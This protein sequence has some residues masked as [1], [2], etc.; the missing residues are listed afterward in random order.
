M[1]IRY[2]CRVALQHQTNPFQ[3]MYLKTLA[4]VLVT[5]PLATRA[6]G[7][8]IKSGS[9]GFLYTKALRGCSL[10]LK[11][12]YILLAITLDTLIL[13]LLYV[14]LHIVRLMYRY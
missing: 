13:T 4:G 10:S 12:S 2:I 3:S 9:L 8:G 14:Y 7:R 11:N 5:L 6:L 1:T